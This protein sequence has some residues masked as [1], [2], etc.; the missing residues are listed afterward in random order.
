MQCLKPEPLY[1]DGSATG[2]NVMR[3]DT[4]VR[5]NAGQKGT[6]KTRNP[7]YSGRLRRSA[8]I[9]SQNLGIL[10]PALAVSCRREARDPKWL[11]SLL[12]E[13]N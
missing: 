3:T 7:V 8:A 11:A 13:G 6:K 4:K 12:E 10:L 2:A 1:L 9:N 5:H